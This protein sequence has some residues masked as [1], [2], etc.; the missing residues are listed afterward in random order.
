[1]EF[2]AYEEFCKV[3]SDSNSVGRGFAGATAALAG[4]T[5]S[6]P[7][8]LIRTRHSLQKSGEADLNFRNLMIFRSIMGV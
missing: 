6:Y 1:M 4:A 8:D 3:L 5:I 7:F 2:G